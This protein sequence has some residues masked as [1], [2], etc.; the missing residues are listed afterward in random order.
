[1]RRQTFP[2]F[3]SSRPPPPCLTPFFRSDRSLMDGATTLTQLE[4]G[5]ASVQDSYAAM[6][7]PAVE[8]GFPSSDG[9]DGPPQTP[10]TMNGDGSAMQTDDVSNAGTGE[11]GAHKSGHP[12]RVIKVLRSSLLRSFSCSVLSTRPLGKDC[13]YLYDFVCSALRV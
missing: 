10:V 5:P 7:Q 3:L 11:G 13:R 6:D 12:D 1:M 4:G 2:S 8:N 9:R